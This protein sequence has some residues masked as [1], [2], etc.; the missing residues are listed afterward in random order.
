MQ[1]W[2]Y[3][4]EETKKTRLN[5]SSGKLGYNVSFES[6]ESRRDTHANCVKNQRAKDLFG[7]VRDGC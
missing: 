6:M 2:A 7:S 1:R 4:A 3:I 5:S